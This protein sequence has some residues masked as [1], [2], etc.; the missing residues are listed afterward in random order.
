MSKLR[1]IKGGAPERKLTADEATRIRTAYTAVADRERAL[2]QITF[3]I[4]LLEEKRGAVARALRDEKAKA[5]TMGHEIAA[6]HGIAFDRPEQG[7]WHLDIA[8]P[9]LAFRRVS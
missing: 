3:E 4:A 9:E 8:A 7:R 2:G 5:E 6:A 1:S